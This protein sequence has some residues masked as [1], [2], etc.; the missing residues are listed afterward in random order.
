MLF[1]HDRPD[2]P[3][4]GAQSGI[5]YAESLD[6]TG[7]SR[8]ITDRI[9]IFGPVDP[10]TM[11]AAHH[12]V[13]RDCEALRLRFAVTA[14][15]PVQYVDPDASS[16]LHLVD[17][18]AEADP[19]AAADAWMTADMTAPVDRLGTGLCTTALIRLA[20]EHFVLY[21][22]V[23]H[24]MVDGWSLAQLHRRT[25]ATYTALV[26]GQAPPAP[27]P[28][29]RILGDGEAAYL[30]SDRLE[31]DRRHWLERLADRPE[32]T[33]LAGR[34][35]RRGGP[36]IRR[37]AHLGV[38]RTERMR[39]AAERLGVGWSEF[40]VGVAAAYV[41]RMAGSTDVL[42]GL[43]VTGRMSRAER[44]VPGMTTNAMPLRVRMPAGTTL[45]GALT[46]VGAEL[47]AGLLHSRYPATMLGRDLGRTGQGRPFW[48][49]VVNVMGS[50]APLRFAD[51]QATV[52]T[53]SLPDV[54]D[55]SLVFFQLPDGDTELLLDADS[56]AHPPGELDA[57]LRRFLFFLDAAT[58]AE[59]GTP[60]DDLPLVDA[61][62]R[63]R[64]LG[65]GRGP[66]R[67]IPPVGVH[68][69]VEE[70]A[71]RTPDA[72][73]LDD[74]GTPVSFR[75]LDRRANRLARHLVDRG[76]G[77]GQVVAFALPRS[78]TLVTAALAVLKSGAAF[79]SLDPAYPVPRLSFMVADAEPSLLLL[80][81]ETAALGD[82]LPVRRLLLDDPELTG[83][84]A[85]LDGRPLSD[86]ERNLPTSPWQPA[87]LIYTS[88]STG[89]PKGVV[90][91]HRGV[92][93]LTAAMVDRL[94]SGPGTRT[95]QFASASF[96]AFVGEMTQSVLN[97]GTLV[98]APADRLTPG[99][100]LVRLIRDREVN[101]LVLAPSV[102]DVLSPQDIPPGTT[103]SIVGELSAPTVVERFAPVCRLINGY[104]PT[105]ATVSTAMSG[106]LTPD[107]AAA[108][109]IGAP[110]RNVRV[111]LLD[112][113]RRL[114]PT[115]TVGELHIGGAGVSLGYRGNR[116]LTEDRFLPDPFATDDGEARMYRS[117]DLA[118]WT[119]DGELVFVGRDDDQVKIRGFRIE[120]G[121]V[122]AALVRQP[123]VVRAAATVRDDGTGGRH[124]VG[125]V[126]P[127]SGTGVDPARIRAGVAE[128][129][130]A[131]LVPGIVVPV[132]EL[133]RTASGKLDRAALPDPHAATPGRPGPAGGGTTGRTDTEE[134]LAA[135]FAELLGVPAV[136]V[137]DNFFDLGGHSLSAT[138]L[139]G[140]ARNLLD[141]HLSV[142]DLF[143][144]PTVSALAARIGPPSVAA[145]GPVAA[146]P[147]RRTGSRPPL[148]CLPLP[149]G[150]SRPWLRLVAQLPAEIPGYGL[151][152]GVTPSA[153][154]EELVDG[155]LARIREVQ[156]E[157]PYHLLGCGTGGYLAYQAAVA[158]QA[159]GA[160]VGLL[161]LLDSYPPDETHPAPPPTDR[162]ALLGV[163]DLYDVPRPASAAPDAATVAAL[164]HERGGGLTG[165]DE[166]A[167]RDQAGALARLGHLAHEFT[168]GRF[169]GDPL[170]LATRR[171]GSGHPPARP[172]W[173]KY[174]TGRVRERLL[175]VDS[176]DPLAPEPVA[177]LAAVLTAAL[178]PGDDPAGAAPA[179]GT[180][181][182]TPAPPDTV[183]TERP[184]EET[185]NRETHR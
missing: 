84:L 134:V 43:P 139:L 4:L 132:D 31:R 78:A 170:V 9:D 80:S 94:G 3:L 32:P 86:G 140:R 68:Q 111:Y 117:G 151:Q 38:T 180:A 22:R 164:L 150:R 181:T 44:D 33:R 105:E 182:G 35:D 98:L 27:P 48:G 20:P 15:G 85:V 103:V 88:G 76:V 65:W 110:L 16:P 67:D 56:V 159:A 135:L 19:E 146:V 7:S 152:G 58:S 70:W 158:L 129:L 101:D 123:G 25:A 99:P 136:G 172:D 128:A 147:L 168:P 127:V 162:E 169:V 119:A 73:A 59:P 18:S 79:L 29:L 72:P 2:W 115:G 74:D 176:R 12:R 109:P 113:H 166:T 157:G 5:W 60:V 133:P 116:A 24:L 178:T 161:A 50:T 171:P 108:P 144:H 42:L 95:L 143:R 57:H 34:Q 14:A 87:Y 102:L 51:H 142:R 13:E 53:L 17:V 106:R 125:Y 83:R 77:P 96:D 126:V 104:G 91:R 40:A 30:A 148:F 163:L 100:D 130:P 173:G 165:V 36:V 1:D 149:D 37:R 75:E 39:I 155:Y 82:H 122:E 21:R 49:A 89:T 145:T 112:P 92:V 185:G 61:E 177:V 153:G 46:A 156:P 93:N 160:E 184:Q 71:D 137:D 183:A 55:V 63:D 69:L 6:P 97:G 124:L 45:A 54:D 175:D 66:T 118:R 154:F 90:V 141:V 47:R 52:R 114:V 8:S 179:G 138:R 64:L 28:P 81:R 167:V 62:E 26:S 131:H 23:H 107:R 41:G 121:E 174:V 120:L 11:T 10:T